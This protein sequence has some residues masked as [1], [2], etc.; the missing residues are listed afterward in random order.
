MPFEIS[1]SNVK[2]IITAIQKPN[3]ELSKERY[4][5]AGPCGIGKTT[6]GKQLSAKLKLHFIDH[7]IMKEKVENYPFPCSIQNL[8]LDDCLNKSLLLEG[9]PNSFVFAIGGYSVFRE[10][11]NN[12]E[13]LAHLLRIKEKYDFVILV[14]T[15]ERAIVEHRFLQLSG[16][17]QDE[18]SSLWRFWEDIENTYWAKCADWII[19]TSNLLL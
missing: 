17:K 19:N 9:N 13:R 16:R 14:L 8:N 18:F 15:A 6:L 2:E 11:A 10:N 7:D 4:F 12:N 3:I 1:C 5:I